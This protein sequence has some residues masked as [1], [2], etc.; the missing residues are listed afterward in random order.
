MTNKIQMKLTEILQSPERYLTVRKLNKL[1]LLEESYKIGLDKVAKSTQAWIDS[2]IFYDMALG[3]VL[4]YDDQ[5]KYLMNNYRKLVDVQTK[6]TELIQQ[7]NLESDVTIP[8]YKNSTL[9]Y[10]IEHTTPPQG[11]ISIARNENM[12]NMALDKITMFRG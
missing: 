12:Q 9:D 1:L 3:G 6:C 7:L 2:P 4:I 8:S 11:E 5:R 10:V